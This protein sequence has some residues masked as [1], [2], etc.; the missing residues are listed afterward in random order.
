MATGGEGAGGAAG[1]DTVKNGDGSGGVGLHT[2]GVGAFGVGW[3]DG[4]RGDRAA[5]IPV[6]RSISTEP[7]RRREG[8]GCVGASSSASFTNSSWAFCAAAR[9]SADRRRASARALSADASPILETNHWN[10]LLEGALY[11]VYKMGQKVVSSKR[12]T[13]GLI[14]VAQGKLKVAG[15]CHIRKPPSNTPL[16]GRKR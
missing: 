6:P 3:G 9:R 8:A 13:D 7:R 14:V 2:G 10:E 5:T 16:L 11:R 4:T 15:G 1:L 12:I